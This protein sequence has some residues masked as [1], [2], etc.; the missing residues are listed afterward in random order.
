MFTIN[1]MGEVAFGKISRLLTAR[2]ITTSFRK[3]IAKS[4]VNPGDI[5]LKSGP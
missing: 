3:R 5:G 4:V 1:V 2:G